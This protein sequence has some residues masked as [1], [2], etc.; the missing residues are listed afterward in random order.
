MSTLFT[1][2]ISGEVPSYKVYEDEYVFAFLDI[3]PVMPGHV[4][5]VPKVE[6]NHF[7]D[8]EEPYY[9]A[10]FAAAKKIS[11]AISK[12][13]DCQRVCTAFV[14]YDIEHCHYHLIP[15]N[16]IDDFN[17]ANSKSANPDD[18]QIMQEKIVQN[19]ENNQQNA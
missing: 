10:I 15:T 11:K 12:A 17:F 4:L 3:Y 7:S 9:S 8:V 13:T 16:G 18:L 1:K 5:V 2:I 19:L 14:G 6:V